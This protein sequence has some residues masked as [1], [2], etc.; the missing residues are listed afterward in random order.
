M[1]QM[2]TFLGI[3]LAHVGLWHEITWMPL[4]QPLLISI[5]Y[6]VLF[7]PSLWEVHDTEFTAHYV[8]NAEVSVY[9]ILKNQSST[10]TESMNLSTV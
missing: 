7:Q 8:L 3:R 6:T 4:G 5:P 9:M 10:C 1:V 2:T